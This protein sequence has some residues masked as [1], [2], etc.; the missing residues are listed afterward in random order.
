MAASH[1]Q[2][3]PPP[4]GSVDV[5]P[6]G[7]V[8]KSHCASGSSRQP[9][10]RLCAMGPRP[11]HAARYPQEGPAAFWGPFQAQNRQPPR[12]HRPQIQARGQTCPATWSPW[13]YVPTLSWAVDLGVGGALLPCSEPSQQALRE[14]WSP[15]ICSLPDSWPLTV[16]PKGNSRRPPGRSWGAITAANEARGRAANREAG[17]TGAGWAEGS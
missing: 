16:G 5:F 10:A 14:A 8:W 13:L 17:A 2:P 7:K 11:C 15:A 12:E 3:Q 4:P 6:R 9:P 1:Y